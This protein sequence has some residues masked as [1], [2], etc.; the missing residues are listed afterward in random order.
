M[1]DMMP[2]RSVP[3]P[4]SSE[5]VPRPEHSRQQVLDAFI[6]GFSFYER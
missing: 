2:E 4:Q 1:N 5:G 3:H 6:A